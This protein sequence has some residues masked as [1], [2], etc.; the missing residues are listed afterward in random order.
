MLAE[1]QPAMHRQGESWR[2]DPRDV[3]RYAER[4]KRGARPIPPGRVL[5]IAVVAL[6]AVAAAV[7]VYWNYEPLRG[8]AEQWLAA[9]RGTPDRDA[10]S[11]EPSS[12]PEPEEIVVEAPVV[13]EAADLPAEV[14][15]APQAA[16]PPA[17]A[18]TRPSGRCR[19]PSPRT[20]LRRPPPR[21]GGRRGAAGACSPAAESAVTA[22]PRSS[23]RQRELAV[24]APAPDLEP[25]AAE[26][27]AA[28]PPPELAPPL[29]EP[30]VP[31][32]PP[33]PETF[34]LA[35][36]V[37]PVSEREAGARVTIRRRGGAL[38]E[39]SIAWW[40]SDGSATA[41]NDYADLGRMTER[42]AAGEESRTIYV[43]IVGD[44]TTESPE[45]FFVN[46]GASGEAAET[47]E[48]AGRAEVIVADD[49]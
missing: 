23:R 17:A 2:L 12:P 19:S 8:R 4:A 44:S 21:V 46:L 18:P 20:R 30:V 7:V 28:V 16:A 48:P 6:A 11:I 38:G 33:A 31:A 9:V 26:S 13:V 45:S 29:A 36:T 24:T 42:F 43:P 34:E 25:R 10:A 15:D 32:E 27:R 40:T 35:R 49:D 1:A 5:R 41:G 14:A 37:V 39:S 22:P 47:S 3:D